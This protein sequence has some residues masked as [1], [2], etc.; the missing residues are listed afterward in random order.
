MTFD[1]IHHVSKKEFP[2]D[3]IKGIIHLTSKINLSQITYTGHYLGMRHFLMLPNPTKK[4]EYLKI[5]S[6]TQFESLFEGETDNGN[7][8]HLELDAK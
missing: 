8:K 7:T 3:F 5:F 2:D 4:L 1:V 6:Q